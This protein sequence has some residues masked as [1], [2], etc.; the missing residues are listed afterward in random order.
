MSITDYFRHQFALLHQRV[1]STLAEI[2]PAMWNATLVPG[3]NRLGFLF[4]HMARGQDCFLQTLIRGTPEV[5]M[6]AP[7]T[8]LPGWELPGI[9]TGFSLVE[10]EAVAARVTISEMQHYEDAV[11]HAIQRWL[12]EVGDADFAHH[13]DCQAHLGGLAAYQTPCG[14]KSPRQ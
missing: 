11:F 1:Q 2:T 10:A 4:W 6:A 7:W 8:S 3:T 5:S 13:P 14:K 12:D 9:G